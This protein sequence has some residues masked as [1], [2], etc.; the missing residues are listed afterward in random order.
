MS[1]RGLAAAMQAAGHA[2]HHTTVSRIE[3]GKQEVTW[4][5]IAPLQRVL[6]GSILEGTGFELL[7]EADQAIKAKRP[8]PSALALLDEADELE[9]A[10]LEQLEE[11]ARKRGEARALLR[12]AARQP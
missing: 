3:N 11:A 6:G 1:Q 7:Y 8:G 12:A 5:E 10:A 2:W 4:A 9:R